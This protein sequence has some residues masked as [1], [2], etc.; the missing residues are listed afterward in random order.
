MFPHQHK[1]PE[2]RRNL[3]DGP[4]DPPVGRG[5]LGCQA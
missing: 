3:P 5:V 2:E 1:V 4:D